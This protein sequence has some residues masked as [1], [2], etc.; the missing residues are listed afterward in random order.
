MI[1]K[2]RIVQ[3]MNRGYKLKEFPLLNLYILVAA[4]AEVF[5]VLV[6]WPLLMNLRP[7][8]LFLMVLYVHNKNVGRKFLV[9][10][11]VSIA[12]AVSCLV[13]LFEVIGDDSSRSIMVGLRMVA[14]W[15]YCTALT[16]GERIR[17]FGELR[18]VMRAVY[19][20]VFS[21]TVFGLYNIR[22]AIESRLIHFAFLLTL[23]VQLCVSLW[24]YEITL[25][26]SFLFS[27]FGSALLLVAAWAEL[28]VAGRA[29][30]VLH[31]VYFCG[32][33]FLAHGSLHQSNLQF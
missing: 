5:A 9:P 18:W 25:R 2:K 6:D 31:F 3:R 8:P 21:L 4:F 30:F 17:P 16:M 13:D 15:I 26:S 14:H 11:L 10:T 27:L 22:E 28:W 1:D 12:L 33:Y 19:C 23:S 20:A 29:V 7:L 24:R 32:H